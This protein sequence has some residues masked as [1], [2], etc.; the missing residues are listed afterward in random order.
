MN[1][2]I[3]KDVFQCLNYHRSFHLFGPFSSWKIEIKRGP[4]TESE[5]VKL[6][7]VDDLLILAI[8]HVTC[9]MFAGVRDNSAE[10]HYVHNIFSHHVT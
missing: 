1:D 9:L 3:R 2:L 7:S 5:F 6:T 8:T 4:W 10:T